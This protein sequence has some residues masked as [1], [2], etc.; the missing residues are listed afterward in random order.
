MFK[1]ALLFDLFLLNADRH[2]CCLV[3]F[4][5]KINLMGNFN[6]NGNDTGTFT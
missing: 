4:T 2:Y 1:G 5:G 3:F 6:T